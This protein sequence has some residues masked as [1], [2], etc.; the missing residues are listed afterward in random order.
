M[1]IRRLGPGDEDVVRALATRPPHFELLEDERTIFLAAFEDGEPIGFVLAHHLPRRHDPPAK[2]LVYEVDVHERH[3]RR[4]VGKALLD[5]LARVARERGI[6]HGW[7]LTDDD[8]DAGM[9]LYRSAGGREPRE[10]IEWEFD[11][12][13]S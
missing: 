7:V 8:N 5:E 9:A 12:E 13:E 2:L 1:E 4:G 10:V 11:Y 6:R 3:R